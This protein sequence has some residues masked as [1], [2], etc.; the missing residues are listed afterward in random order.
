M[1]QSLAFIRL[2]LI[3][4]IG[5]M[6]ARADDWPQFRGANRDAIW[7][8]TGILTTFPAAGLKVAW[9]A[10]VGYGLSSPV[11]AQGR[12]FLSDAELQKPK[13]RE[14][15]HCFDEKTG[16][17]LWTHAHEVTYPTWAFDPSQKAGP[18]STP[19]VQDGKVWSLGMMG[20]L[21]CLDAVQG[22]EVWHKNLMQDY[23]MKE[24]SGTTPCPLIDGNRLILTIGCKPDVSVLALDK[25]TGKEIWRALGD[26]VTYSSPIIIEAGGQRQLIT[27]TP[28]AVT[29]L[30]PVTG[31]TWWREE[32]NTTGDYGVATPVHH[33][34]LLLISGLMFQLDATKPAATV[35]W[36]SIKPMAKRIFSHTS[37]P[38]ILGDHV[39]AGKMSG[40]LVCVEA[41]TGKVIWETDKVTSKG[42]GAAIHLTPNGDTVLLFT[43]QGNLI[44][45][46]L[47]PKGYEELS[48][49]PVIKPTY[50]FAGRM[51]VW[52]PPAYANGHVF[53]RNE[54]ELVCASLAAP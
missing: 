34:D 52:P 29:S 10:P 7:K 49:V 47:T 18:N 5:A 19:I 53:A 15:L 6:G 11:I 48:R 28:K 26:P 39:Y 24:F 12:V 14:R 20:D 41:R 50:A 45:A 51:L 36:P 17:A 54:E 25:A 21:F 38:I 44:R 40:Q 31:K 37:M 1:N 33:G 8:E 9:R 4:L 22:T 2:T 32:L 3:F 16:K 13:G 42:Q 43:D 23:G 35:L 30:D 46:K 27:W